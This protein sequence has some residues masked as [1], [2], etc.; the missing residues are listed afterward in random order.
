MKQHT[1]I[2]R[3]RGERLRSSVG[4]SGVLTADW[5][6]TGKSPA[7]EVPRSHRLTDPCWRSV[8]LAHVERSES[9]LALTILD[10]EGDGEEWFGVDGVMIVI[11]GVALRTLAEAAGLP[12]EFV[13]PPVNLF[14][15]DP[16]W[17]GLRDWDGTG[18]AYYQGQ[19]P[20]LADGCG[21]PGCDALLMSVTATLD[22]VR[23]SDF[24]WYRSRNG[25]LGRLGPFEFRRDAYEDEF[26]KITK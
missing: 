19:I 21:A 4:R 9:R 12:G 8:I 15:R 16:M 3:R 14:T 11:D 24:R 6:P 1:L 20:I 22:R 5:R 2:G 26:T 13:Y 17:T 25:G 7:G 10:V 18:G 23:W